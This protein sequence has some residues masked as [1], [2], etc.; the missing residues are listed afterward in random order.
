MPKTITQ[1][2][3]QNSAEEGGTIEDGN[4]VEGET[5]RLLQTGGVGCQIE[6]RGKQAKKEDEASKTICQEFGVLQDGQTCFDVFLLTMLTSGAFLT[7]RMFDCGRA[8][9]QTGNGHQ[10]HHGK[11]DDSYRPGKADTVA[12]QRFVDH[13]RPDDTANG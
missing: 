7:V 8:N 2:A 10:W 9:S 6:Q 5:W 13:D 4:E 3:G 11:A 1:D 12:I